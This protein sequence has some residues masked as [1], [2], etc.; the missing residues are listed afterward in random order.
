ML[1]YR[2]TADIVLLCDFFIGIKLQDPF[3]NLCL[4]CSQSIVFPNILHC[5]Q[6]GTLLMIS[7]Y[8]PRKDLIQMDSYGSQK[9]HIIR[10]PFLCLRK[11]I[12]HAD[13]F[14]LIQV[15][16]IHQ[17]GC[18][19][20]LCRQKNAAVCMRNQHTDRHHKLC[21]EFLYGGTVIQMIDQ[22]IIN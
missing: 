7:G 10:I 20:R 17:R 19:H 21:F 4:P 15:F 12:R 5:P 3:Q 1:L 6:S 14:R 11:G 9:K 2:Q 8:N 16:G 22:V 18:P 13:C